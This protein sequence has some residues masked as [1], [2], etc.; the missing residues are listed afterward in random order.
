MSIDDLLQKASKFEALAQ[1]A[2]KPTPYGVYD[3]LR[4]TIRGIAEHPA[5][6]P[7]AIEKVWENIFD[8]IEWAKIPHQQQQEIKR[9]IRI[10]QLK[11]AEELRRSTM[12]AEYELGKSLTLQNE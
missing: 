4:K 10:A 11:Q 5:V 6:I 8:Q 12:E 3:I 2:K 1:S 9:K 7:Q